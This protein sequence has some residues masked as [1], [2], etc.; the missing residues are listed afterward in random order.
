MNRVWFKQT[1]VLV[2]VFNGN[3]SSTGSYEHIPYRKE[4]LLKGLSII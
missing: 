3:Q 1:N 4:S 2:F